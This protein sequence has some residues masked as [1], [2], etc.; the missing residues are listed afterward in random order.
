MRKGIILHLLTAVAYIVLGI[1][2]YRPAIASDIKPRIAFLLFVPQN[3][4]ATSLMET[5]PTILTS[6][7]NRR[8]YF[9]IMERKKVDREILLRGYQISS[10]K[11]EELFRIG[12]A[13]G[14]DFSVYGDVKKDIST[15]TASIKVL[16]I[17]AQRLCFEQTIMVSEGMLNDRLNELSTVIAEQTLKCFS[18]I[19]T[20]KKEEEYLEQP[21]DLKTEEADKKMKLIWKH[22]NMQDVSGFKIYRATDKDE[23][24]LLAGMAPD[25][26]FVDPSPP[27]NKPVFY[28]IAAVYK[29]GLES[30]PSSVVEARIAVGPSPP[31]FLNITSDIKSAHLKWKAHPKSEVSGFKIYRKGVA[32]K[33]FKEITSVPGDITTYTDGGL[34]DD[35]SYYYALSS[36]DSNG[37]GGDL[38]VILK[39]VTLK[40]PDGF[41]A[42]G[43][44]IRRIPLSWSILSSEVVKGYRIYRSTDKTSGEQPIAEIDGKTSSNY[45]DKKDLNDLITYWY[46]ISAYN[47]EGIE[48]GG[49]EAVSATTRGQPPVPQGFTAKDREPRKVSLK[50]DV[51]KSPDDEVRGYII[52]RS[53]EEKVEY[54]K[55]AEIN[56][57]EENSFNDKDPPLKDDTTYYYRIASH[58]SAGM[59]SDLSTPIPSTT[60]AFPAVPRGFSAK[61]GEVK[62]VTLAWEPNPEQDIKGYN[63][64]KA[65][66]GDK[67]LKNI[68]FVKGKTDYIDTE[69]KDGTTYI[70]TIEAV[71]E[72]NLISKQSPPATAVTKS[73]PVKPAGLKISDEGER[74]IL[75]WDA[76]PEKDIKQYNIYKKGFLGTSRK[77]ATVQNNSWV[78]DEVKG[79]LEIFVTALDETGLES[80]GSDLILIEGKK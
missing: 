42:E 2:S 37:T 49:S 69:L 61:S 34:N 17:K 50:W 19:V 68:A 4:E 64:Y 56:N 60:K 5:I 24:Y 41:K 71:D 27:L 54:K 58:N 9:E 10:L 66:S 47:N 59:S 52:F 44:K 77:L 26:T 31:I 35:T 16:D 38:S 18:S 20:S 51:I 67:S 46:R 13:L 57:P 25:L 6:A 79:K 21:Y 76:N 29:N 80:E 40:A 62:Q 7:V 63:V 22:R 33:E 48:T 36:V 8:N 72:D 14:L 43:G 28:K 74:K 53:T 11:T 45:L 23:A 12:N 73:I 78:I 1:G 30:E 3:I 39:T 32:D 15:I 75:H 65:V 55:I 70:Y